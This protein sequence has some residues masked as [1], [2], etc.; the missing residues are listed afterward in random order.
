MIGGHNDFVIERDIGK[1][2]PATAEK[3]EKVSPP[4]PPNGQNRRNPCIRQS[5]RHLRRRPLRPRPGKSV[6]RHR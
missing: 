2:T 5:L 3:A 4:L 1:A 6:R